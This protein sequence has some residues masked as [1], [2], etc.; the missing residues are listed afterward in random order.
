MT[1]SIPSVNLTPRIIFG[2][3]LWPLRRCQLFSAASA[4]LK[5]MASA[6]L[7]ERHPLERTVR[8]RTVA[9]ELSMGLV[10]RRCSRCNLQRHLLLVAKPPRGYSA[11]GRPILTKISA[12]GPPPSPMCPGRTQDPRV[13]GPDPAP[14]TTTCEPPVFFGLP[15]RR[16]SG[17]RIAGSGGGFPNRPNCNSPFRRGRHGWAKPY[18]RNFRWALWTRRSRMTLA[19]GSPVDLMPT[20]HGKLR[21]DDRRA[22]FPGRVIA[23]AM[24]TTAYTAIAA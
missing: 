8:W 15:N 19:S 12:N 10:V 13:L 22:C 6:V 2:N 17:F 18:A 16:W 1:T 24:W 14:A 23:R 5:I 4:S 20:V 7:L 21:S 9:N 11:D 3:W